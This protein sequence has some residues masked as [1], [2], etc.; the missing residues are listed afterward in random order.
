MKKRL[1]TLLIVFIMLFMPILVVNASDSWDTGDCIEDF[2]SITFDSAGSNNDVGGKVSYSNAKNNNT[3]STKTVTLDANIIATTG[4]KV[5]TIGYSINSKDGYSCTGII[6]GST[7]ENNSGN[8][9]IHVKIDKGWVN[10]IAFWGKTVNRNDPTKSDMTESNK[11]SVK[12]E[13]TDAELEAIDEELNITTGEKLECDTLDDL[14]SK[15]WTWVLILMPVITL[16]LI[17]IDFVGAMLASDSD[18][19]KKSSV[20]ALKRVTALVILLLLPVIIDLLFG[21]F[22]IE[23]CF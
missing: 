2:G 22:S 14:L 6:K 13:M 11:I 23:T 21:I 5:K 12:R 19:L 20:K 15:Y 10:S 8:V 4:H 9:K 7:V 1:F 17:T 3:W 16:L 18:A